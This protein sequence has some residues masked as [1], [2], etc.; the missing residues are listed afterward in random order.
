MK[1]PVTAVVYCV[2]LLPE[3]AA[4]LRK[5]VGS[6]QAAGEIEVESWFAP[7]ADAKVLRVEPDEPV[8]VLVDA[9]WPY[10]VRRDSPGQPRSSPR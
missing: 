8:A 6:E 3:R 5:C 4:E 1:V 10:D 7:P 2:A 9:D